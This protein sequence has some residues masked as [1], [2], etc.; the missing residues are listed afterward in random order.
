M[1]HCPS[2]KYSLAQ[3]FSQPFSKPDRNAFILLCR[4]SPPKAFP[5]PATAHLRSVRGTRP[6]PHTHRRASRAPH[7]PPLSLACL[8]LSVSPKCEC[9][10][11]AIF[12]HH[13]FGELQMMK[14]EYLSAI[15]VGTFE[16]FREELQ[17]PVEWC[18]ALI[19]EKG[20]NDT[21]A[22]RATIP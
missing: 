3:Y 12:P 11:S 15:H 17:Y 10:I 19:L 14:C 22:K 16:Y 13:R 4:S 18:E 5:P 20:G 7:S 21:P 8:V 9:Y 2:Q 6:R 1:F